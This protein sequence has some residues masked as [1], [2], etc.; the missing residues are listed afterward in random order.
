MTDSKFTNNF[1]I[2]NDFKKHDILRKDEHVVNNNL[3]ITNSELVS[4]KTS[5]MIYE[6]LININNDLRNNIKLGIAIYKKLNNFEYNNIDELF[7]S[8]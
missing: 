6:S 8:K 2:F 1:D 4:E 3:E 5:K 7:K